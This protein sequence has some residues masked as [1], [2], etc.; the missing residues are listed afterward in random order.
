MCA[1]AASWNQEARTDIAR[2]TA[3]TRTMRAM[4]SEGERVKTGLPEG[5]GGWSFN[6][7]RHTAPT[8]QFGRGSTCLVHV[9][10]TRIN[11]EIWNHPWA[12]ISIISRSWLLKPATTVCSRGRTSSIPTIS[13]TDP[14]MKWHPPSQL[15]PVSKSQLLPSSLCTLRQA[16]RVPLPPPNVYPSHDLDPLSPSRH[17]YSRYTQ[18]VSTR[19]EK[20]LSKLNVRNHTYSIPYC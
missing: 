3:E 14:E 10:A 19:A 11:L 16:F 9:T 6:G 2:R 8:A 4:A 15:L 17:M 13:I 7:K 12:N 5:G 1:A 18:G 20:V